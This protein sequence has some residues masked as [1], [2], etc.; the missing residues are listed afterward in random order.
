MQVHKYK[1]SSVHMSNEH[2]D[3]GYLV[4]LVGEDPLG[5]NIPR[6]QEKARFCALLAE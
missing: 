5:E 2:S 1:P 6:N 3:F 4:C